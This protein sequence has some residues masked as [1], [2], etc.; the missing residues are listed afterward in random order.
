METIN[1]DTEVIENKIKDILSYLGENPEREG[2][3]ETPKRMIKSWEKLFG[4]YKQNPKEILKTTFN[5]GKCNEMVILKNIEFYS[6]CE[7]HF[8]PF[9]GIVHV[10][11]IPNKSVVG[12]SKLARLIEVFARRL[13]IQER[14]TTQIADAIMEYLNTLGTIVI[15][16]AQHLC[17]TARGIEKQKSIM[18]TS[19]IRG[20][21]EKSK[22]R[23]EFLQIIGKT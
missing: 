3:K 22:A 7:H 9:S 23:N 6:T 11:Y 14:L 2:L 8:L 18:I 12:I 16:E 1:S 21:F 13:Q 19:A 5:E 10:A 15:I 17:M 4:G 20:V